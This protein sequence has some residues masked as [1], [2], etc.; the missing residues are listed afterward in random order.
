MKMIA[1]SFAC[2]LVS[3][4]FLAGADERKQMLEAVVQAGVWEIEE[5]VIPRIKLVDGTAFEFIELMED[6]IGEKETSPIVVAVPAAKLSNLRVQVDL[7]DVPLSA[8]MATFSEVTRLDTSMR[9]GIWWVEEKSYDDDLLTR[10]YRLG[11]E[12]LKG[13][14]L[15]IAA[16]AKPNKGSKVSRTGGAAWPVGEGRAASY[17]SGSANL[18][19]QLTRKEIAELDAIFLLRKAGYEGLKVK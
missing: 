10:V 19:V 3:A 12:E 14:G 5:P 11:P 16:A 8:A 13:I 7:K 9:E 4:G 1:Y 17:F 15:E 6:A 2:L 18:V